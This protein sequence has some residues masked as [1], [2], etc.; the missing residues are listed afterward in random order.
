MKA[1]ANKE[2]I[3][4]MV[5]GIVICDITITFNGENLEVVPSYKS[6]ALNLNMVIIKKILCKETCSRKHGKL[7]ILWEKMQKN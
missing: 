3:L 4:V 1:N 6:R 7:F 2:I 5:F